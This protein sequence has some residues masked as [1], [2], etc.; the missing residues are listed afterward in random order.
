MVCDRGNVLPR[1]ERAS[2]KING[3]MAAC[4]AVNGAG[5]PCVRIMSPLSR[6][7]GTTCPDSL[8]IPSNRWLKSLFG[9]RQKRQRLFGDTPE[10][11]R[12]TTEAVGNS[13]SAT[14]ASASGL[15]ASLPFVR[16]QR[17]REGESRRVFRARR[18]WRRAGSPRG[19]DAEA[20]ARCLIHLAES[21]RG[22]ARKSS[23]RAAP[24]AAASDNGSV[25]HCPVRKSGIRV[26]V[27]VPLTDRPRIW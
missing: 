1:V 24:R 22:D 8:R 27:A 14:P 13:P 19:A 18:D 26:R 11:P 6:I 17:R 16:R 20:K 4:E 25:C 9:C 3:S 12:D 21:C 7:F 23:E 2:R 10:A 15:D 5:F